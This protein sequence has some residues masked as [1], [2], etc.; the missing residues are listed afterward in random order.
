MNDGDPAYPDHRYLIGI[1]AGGTKIHLRRVTRSEEP[2]GDDIIPAEHWTELGPD[3]QAAILTDRLRALG[4]DRPAAI[5]IG[6]HGCDTDTEAATLAQA[7]RRRI[8][9]ATAVVNDAFLLPAAHSRSPLT[10]DSA[11]L[12]VG[13]GSIAVARDA[14][15][16]S[17]YVGGW[18]WLLGDPGSAWG[19]VREAVRQ[20]TLRA[21]RAEGPEQDRLGRALLDRSQTHSLRELVTVMEQQPATLWAR[22]AATVYDAADQGSTTAAAVI[23]TAVSELVDMVATLC[24]RGAQVTGVVAGGGVI[25]QQ[26]VLEH[27]LRIELGRRL[28]LTLAVCQNDPVD[29]AVGIARGLT[30]DS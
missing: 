5:G 19:T 18:G 14:A 25:T 23:D 15:G 20:L 11:G 28:D 30:R 16:R 8:H 1:D 13:T 26:P 22:W 29:G 7:I 9:V 17:L 21:D 12:V 6:A 24:D 3:Q 2:A 27:R 4:W 10:G